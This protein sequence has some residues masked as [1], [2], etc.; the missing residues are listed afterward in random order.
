[1][2][3][4]LFKYFHNHINSMKTIFGDDEAGRER[5]YQ[6]ADVVILMVNYALI[7]DHL[8]NGKNSGMLYGRC[9]SS[10]YGPEVKGDH[11]FVVLASTY[12]KKQVFSFF[13]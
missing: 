12:G 2:T 4:Y 10:L 8:G 1:M 6:S 13:T 7:S 9:T 5:L 3:S 11:R